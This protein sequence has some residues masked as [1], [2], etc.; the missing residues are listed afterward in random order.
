[1]YILTYM[2]IRMN[3]TY[4]IVAWLL[5]LFYSSI[6]NIIIDSDIA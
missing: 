1:M 2:S 4:V 5:T 3:V 6:I